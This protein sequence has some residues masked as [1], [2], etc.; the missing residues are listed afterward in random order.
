LETELRFGGQHL[1]HNLLF[2]SRLQTDV[3]EARACNLDVLHPQLVSGRG[4]QRIAQLLAKLTWVELERFR[5]LHGRR[6]GKVAMR[7]HLGGFKCG[8][9]A[10]TGQQPI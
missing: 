2:R 1:A 8:C 7:S 5:Q 3:D 4:Q 10:A 6:D 9:V